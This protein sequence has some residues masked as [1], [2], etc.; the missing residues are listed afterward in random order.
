MTLDIVASREISDRVR[1]WRTPVRHRQYPKTEF[2]VRRSSA[3]HARRSGANVV[4]D[5]DALLG[6]DLAGAV[7]LQ[8]LMVALPHSPAALLDHLPVLRGDCGVDGPFAEAR[9]QGA[10]YS[11]IRLWFFHDIDGKA[12][13]PGAVDDRLA[14]AAGLLAALIEPNPGGE[15]VLVSER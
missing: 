14:Q 8:E 2:A 11:L 6:E 7:G 13:E 4:D 1:G 9:R 12:I 5:L 15:P 3:R 10:Q